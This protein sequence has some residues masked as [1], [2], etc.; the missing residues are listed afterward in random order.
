MRGDGDDGSLVTEATDLAIIIPIG[1]KE[2][3]WKTLLMDLEPL[4]GKSEII[5]VGVLGSE[6]ELD[7]LDS[8][9]Q[10]VSSPAGRALQ[11]NTGAKT[12]TRRYLWF[13]H[14][15][16][17]VTEGSTRKL[18]RAL[19]DTPLGIHYFDLRFDRD[20]GPLTLLNSA[21]VWF[22]S[23]A[24]KL[25]FGDQ[26]FCVDQGS[27]AHLQGYD[28]TAPFGEDHLFIWKAHHQGIRV[29]PVGATIKTS[30]RRYQEQGWLRTT[31]TTGRLT[32]SQALPELIKMIRGWTRDL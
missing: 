15:D 25:P 4:R 13:L 3:K 5:L 6:P 19:D 21:G 30:S 1:P 7:A 32:W 16:S 12:S 28:E 27:F 29:T 2:E 22:R 23:H 8:G 24:L 26:G 18:F 20:A 11:L 10:C 31:A 9:I 17:R 14:A